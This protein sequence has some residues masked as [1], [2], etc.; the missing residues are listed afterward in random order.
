VRMNVQELKRV[1]PRALWPYLGDVRRWVRTIP[2][3]PEFQ[4]KRLFS[5][6]SLSAPERE[7]LGKVSAKIYYRDRMYDPDG[8][9]YF[10]IGLRAIQS[11]NAALAQANLTD[12]RTILDLPS[13]GGRVLR[14]LSPR[15]P[16]AKITACDIQRG[17]VDF[18]RDYLGAE[19]A[20]SSANL[21]EL[22]LK[23]KFDLIWC[24]SLVT[25][26]NQGSMIDLLKFFKR[27][28]NAGSLLVFTTHGDHVA[29]RLPKK[30][31]DYGLDDEQLPALIDG[32]ERNGFGFAPWPK[33]IYDSTSEFGVSLTSPDW[34]DGQVRMVGGMRKVYFASRGW[35]DHQ[36]VFGFVRE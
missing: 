31:F 33:G 25:H 32:Y 4:K 9:D 20:Y 30:E 2:P 21:N 28:L 34:I 15:F 13:G 26:F 12:V 19:P 3:R 10:K 17:A 1:V 5:D 22:S 23:T 14:F 24:G 7:L 27:H 11:I 18:C 16:E 8:A 35:D 36:D 6:P 29:A